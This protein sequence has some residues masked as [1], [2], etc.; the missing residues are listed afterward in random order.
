MEAL[1]FLR[2]WRPTT[3]NIS[4]KENQICSGNKSSSTSSEAT[5]IS[6]LVVESCDMLLDGDQ[7]EAEDSFFELELT[8]S[9]FDKKRNTSTSTTH[10]NTTTTTTTTNSNRFDNSEQ[11]KQQQQQQQQVHYN[12][13]DV[14]SKRKILPIEPTSKPQSPI[15]LLKSAP[16]LRVS[17][18]KKS[19]SMATTTL[20]TEKTE[21]TETQKHENKLFTVKFKVEQEGSTT[22]NNNNNNNNNLS[23]FTRVCSLRKTQQQPQ[24]SHRD[25]NESVRSYDSS[26]S[27][28]RFSKDVIQ[29]YLKLIKPLYVKVSKKNDNKMAM[30]RFSAEESP[31]ASP[32]TALM[33]SPK[34]GNNITA[35]FRVVSR[36]LGKSKSASSTAAAAV[37]SPA[38]RDDSLL[39]QHD[40]I[41]SAILHCKKSFNSSRDSSSLSRS[42]STSSQETFSNLSCKDSSLF[43]RFSSDSLSEESIL[44]RKSNEEGNGL[45]EFKRERAVCP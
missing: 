12:S 3:N 41:Q 43:S 6:N 35:G 45:L 29:K 7:E 16:K 13:S 24:H 1:S 36:H 23:I 2:F 26:S 44:S 5:E 30:T 10:N 17:I 38:R 27:S 8:V 19:K 21:R 22:N 33:Q 14:L 9:D 37:L 40:G 11:Q 42:T 18:F 34:Q 4:H 31:A 32:A 20:K 25:D 15:A 28:K 39:L